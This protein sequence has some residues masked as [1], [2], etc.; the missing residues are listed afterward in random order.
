MPVL[1][2]P[3]ILSRALCLLSSRC[4]AGS[5]H[6]SR[7]LQRSGMLDIGYVTGQRVSSLMF[8]INDAAATLCGECEGTRNH[9]PVLFADEVLVR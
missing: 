4:F 1:G 3:L 8:A 7:V 9:V 5:A 2:D 6:F